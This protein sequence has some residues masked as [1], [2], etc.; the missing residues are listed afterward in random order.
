MDLVTAALLGFAI[1]FVGSVPIAGPLA[2]LVLDKALAG[3]KQQGFFLALGGSLVEAAY[4]LAVALLLPVLLGHSDEVI[5]V[6]RGLGGLVIGVCG[7][8]LIKRPE[9]LQRANIP[10][11]RG[12]F[13]A[14]VTFTALNPT[15]IATYTLVLSTLYAEDLLS[16]K[17]TASLLFALGVCGGVVVWFVLLLHFTA[18]AKS[19]FGGHRRA[20]VTRILG[21]VLVGV[22]VYLMVRFVAAAQRRFDVVNASRHPRTEYVVNVNV[23]AS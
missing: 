16:R 14:G 12:H 1:A 6:S 5:I 9:L 23:N 11:K 2:V 4:A 19:F 13:L 18:W 21:G 15:L 20:M 10:S 7:V 3:R 17:V 8:V 22:S